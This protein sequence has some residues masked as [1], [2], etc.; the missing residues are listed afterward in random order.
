MIT[1]CHVNIWNDEHV[2]PHYRTQMARV[3]EKGIP[4]KADA[5]TIIAA[6]APVDRAIVFA[7]RYAETIGIDSDDAVTADAVRRHPEKLTGFAYADP[8]RPDCRAAAP[9][10]R[11]SASSV[12][13]R[14][15]LQRRAARRPEA[16]AG[17]CLL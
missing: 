12:P 6:M 7:L 17:L 4:E 1:D 15:D 3:R 10:R 13:A 5:E 16:R 14:A 8:R 9:R 11:G 2:L